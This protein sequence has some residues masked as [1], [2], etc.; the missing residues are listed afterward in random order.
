MGSKLC[1]WE[2]TEQAAGGQCPG[3]WL[4][5]ALCRPGAWLLVCAGAQPWDS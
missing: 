3:P 5:G 4:G 2:G 1:A